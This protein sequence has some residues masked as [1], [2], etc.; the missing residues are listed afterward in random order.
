[1]G[2]AIRKMETGVSLD[3]H[4]IY[5]GFFTTSLHL[6]TAGQDTIRYHGVSSPRAKYCYIS[7]RG[8]KATDATTCHDRQYRKRFLMKK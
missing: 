3:R 8:T 2:G 1:M 6:A 5:L 7:T 4:G